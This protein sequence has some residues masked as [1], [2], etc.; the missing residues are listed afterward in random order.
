LFD[1]NPPMRNVAA[2][3]IAAVSGSLQVYV[4]YPF[5]GLSGQ[6]LFEENEQQ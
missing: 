5:V 6:V 1:N 3:C 4:P 2:A